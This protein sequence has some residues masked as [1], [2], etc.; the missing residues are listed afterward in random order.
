MDIIADDYLI[1]TALRRKR[2]IYDKALHYAYQ[3]MV[4]GNFYSVVIRLITDEKELIRLGYVLPV[5]VTFPQQGMGEVIFD[6]YIDVESFGSFQHVVNLGLGGGKVLT[7]VALAMVTHYDTY[8]VGGYL[9]QAAT[10]P[11]GGAQRFVTLEETYDYLLGLRTTPR[12]NLKTGLLKKPPTP[13]LPEGMSAF[14]HTSMGV[15][16]VIL[17]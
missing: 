8:G 16:Y 17:C 13:L 5:G 11:S 4:G 15:S 9:F 7:K 12:I 6:M 2:F 3:F 14:K 1:D 10:R